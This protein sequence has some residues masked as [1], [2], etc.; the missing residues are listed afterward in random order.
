M[1]LLL[2]CHLFFAIV[3]FGNFIFTFSFGAG[4]AVYLFTQHAQVPSL[5]LAKPLFLRDPSIPLTGSQSA[6][7][8]GKCLGPDFSQLKSPLR[9]RGQ[10]CIPSEQGRLVPLQGPWLC[11]IW[12][13]ESRL[14]TLSSILAFLPVCQPSEG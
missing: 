3:D 5:P 9:E 2:T 11:K 1:K 13:C 14:E 12:H 6:V 7:P 10:D 4:K 8:A